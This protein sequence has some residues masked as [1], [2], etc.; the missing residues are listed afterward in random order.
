[1]LASEPAVSILSCLTLQGKKAAEAKAA[2]KST[3]ES[4]E[5]RRV[6]PKRK[7]AKRGKAA[8]GLEAEGDDGAK[9]SHLG[10][11]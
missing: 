4:G 1:L 11:G 6:P 7:A 10:C 8:A 9:G 5:S 3:P 2:P